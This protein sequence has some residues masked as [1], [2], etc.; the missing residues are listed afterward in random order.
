M[1][2]GGTALQ[3]FKLPA[4]IRFFPFLVAALTLIAVTLVCLN[5][6]DEDIVYLEDLER[7]TRLEQIALENEK[8]ALQQEIS[9]KDTDAYIMSTA[10]SLYGYLMPGEIRFQVTNISDLYTE[11]EATVIEV[12]E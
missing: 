9:I 10:R 3:K 1:P 2:K 12:G 11:P 6:L 5:N 8:S 4:R 7:K